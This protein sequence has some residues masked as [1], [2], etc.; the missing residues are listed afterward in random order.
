MKSISRIFILVKIGFQRL[1][2]VLHSLNAS[3]MSM[4]GSDVPIVLTSMQEKGESL[5][6]TAITYTMIEI[7]RDGDEKMTRLPESRREILQNLIGFRH[8]PVCFPLERVAMPATISHTCQ[9]SKS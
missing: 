2:E 7:P 8:V 6:G 9:L 4:L 1:K 5:M 3:L